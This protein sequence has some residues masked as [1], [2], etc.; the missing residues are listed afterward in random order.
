MESAYIGLF[1]FF[2]FLLLE[3]YVMATSKHC[4][5]LFSLIFI[6]KCLSKSNLIS[7]KL[8]EKKKVCAEKIISVI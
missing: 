8:K 2:F 7:R 4:A 5:K 6:L 3:N 1:E